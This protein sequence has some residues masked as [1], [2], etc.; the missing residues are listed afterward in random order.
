MKTH[1]FFFFLKSLFY[2]VKA[3]IIHIWNSGHAHFIIFW[4]LEMSMAYINALND[5]AADAG[6]VQSYVSDCLWIAK[7]QRDG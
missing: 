5:E 1:N 3:W 2:D 6:L 4:F 7:Q